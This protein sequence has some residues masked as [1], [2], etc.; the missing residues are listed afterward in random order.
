MSRPTSAPPNIRSATHRSGRAWTP[1]LARPQRS[2]RFEEA[3]KDSGPLLRPDPDAHGRSSGTQ[4]FG[5]GAGS[6]SARGSLR[7][8][9]SGEPPAVALTAL[10]AHSWTRSVLPF[11]GT[12]GR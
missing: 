6:T 1:D 9:P 4:L 3:R 7:S 8:V 2:R 5:V 10:G 12:A 11:S